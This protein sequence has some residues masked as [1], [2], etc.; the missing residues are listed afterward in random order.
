MP[1]LV[2]LI[3]FVVMYMLMI[4]PQQRRAR[5]H[6]ALVASVEIGD[7]VMTTAGIFGT[8]TA[9]ED[10]AVAMEIAPGVVVRVARAAIGQRVGPEPVEMDDDTVLGEPADEIGPAE[11]PSATDGPTTSPEPPTE[12]RRDSPW[13]D[14]GQPGP[15]EH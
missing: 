3:F 4:R 5:E 11:T 10:N 14:W 9:L 13:G 15:Q 7:E 12:P 2:L 6:Q 1:L 8:I